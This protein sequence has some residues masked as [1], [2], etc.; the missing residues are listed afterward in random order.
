MGKSFVLKDAS[1]RPGGYLVQGM[2]DICCR[3]GHLTQPS[4]MV[5]LFDDG[6]QQTHAIESG[7]E[8]YWPGGGGLL[9]GGFLCADGR[10]LLAT[11]EAARAAFERLSGQKRAQ[12][13]RAR[14][15]TA[16]EGKAAPPPREEPAQRP[17]DSVRQERVWPQ[18]RW[19]PPPCW[20][21]AEY[22]QG[23]WQERA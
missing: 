6:T 2:R 10:L 15:E 4:E 8:A 21:Q 18:R 9:C 11:G 13:T 12:Q 17:P 1:G 20:P 16:G 3:A 7:E 22:A 19:P 14:R 23:R 5:L